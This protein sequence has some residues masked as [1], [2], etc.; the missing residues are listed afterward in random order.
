MFLNNKI[1]EIPVQK[2]VKSSSQEIREKSF[3]NLLPRGN[4]F[5]IVNLNIYISILSIY[6]SI[7][8]SLCPSVCESLGPLWLNNRTET[9]TM[10]NG[11]NWPSTNHVTNMAEGGYNGFNRIGQATSHTLPIC[12]HC[13]EGGGGRGPVDCWFSVL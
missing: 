8:E 2:S 7:S 13:I 11:G 12:A 9:T 3:P 5:S 6:L 10:P 1:R 4:Q